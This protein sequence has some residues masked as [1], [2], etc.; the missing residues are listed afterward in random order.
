MKKLL[1]IVVLGLLW[2]SPALAATDIVDDGISL[3]GILMFIGAAGVLSSTMGP[4]LG[5]IVTI[6]ITAI[7]LSN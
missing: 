2:C 4:V 1:G 5:I 7:V 3:Y 6:I